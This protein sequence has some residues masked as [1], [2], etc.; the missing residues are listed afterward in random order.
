MMDRYQ[1]QIPENFFAGFEALSQ[2]LNKA[3][4]QLTESLQQVGRLLPPSLHLLSTHGWYVSDTSTITEGII[5]AAEAAKGNA[6]KVDNTLQKFYQKQCSS[7]ILRLKKRFPER[8]NILDEALKAHKRKMFYSSTCLF[9]S[10][11]DG[12]LD[13]TLFKTKGDKAN[14][15]KHLNKV[16]Y[17]KS[18]ENAI[19]TVS[20]IDIP[21]SKKSKFP[22]SLNRHS[23]LHGLDFEYGT[24]LNSLKAQ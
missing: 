12:L 19:T 6:E 8:A 21:H 13:G 1:I 23:V 7:I 18:L 14:L 17:L 9:L 15:K 3:A 16:T 4:K 22:S 24:Q 11:A 20:A 10:T 5:L 2:E